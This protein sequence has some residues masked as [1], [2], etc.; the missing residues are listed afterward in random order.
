MKKLIAMYKEGRK[1]KRK[2]QKENGFTL[3]EIIAVFLLVAALYALVGPYIWNRLEQGRVQAARAQLS[4]FKNCLD[5]YRLD[6]GSYPSADEGLEALRQ[7]P[8]T[9]S[10]RWMG[11]YIEGPIPKDPWGNSYIYRFPGEKNPGGY[12]LYSLGADGREGGDGFDAEIRL[13]DMEEETVYEGILE[14]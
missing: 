13:W 11:P 10:G 9:N 3:M 4:I 14:P 12:D 8:A 5:Y 6:M 1:I 7:P 2:L